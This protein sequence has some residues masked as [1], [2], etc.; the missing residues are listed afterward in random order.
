M[1]DLTILARELEE[2]MMYQQMPSQLEVKD[3][4]NLIV[5]G[6][7]TMYIDTGRATTW[8]DDMIEREPGDEILAGHLLL[9]ADLAI[10]EEKYVLLTAQI[11]LI[12][13]IQGDVNTIVGYTTDALSVTNADKPYEHL[14]DSIEKLDNERRITYYKMVRYTME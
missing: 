6:V 1:T 11:L 9:K 7:K 4:E 8:S 13:R 14:A 12:Q 3:Y 10:D 5:S 2:R